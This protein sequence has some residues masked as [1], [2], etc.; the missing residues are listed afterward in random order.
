MLVVPLAYKPPGVADSTTPPSALAEK[1]LDW[2]VGSDFVFWM[3]LRVARDQ[4]IERV[5]GTPPEQVSSASAADQVRV[6]AI[7]NDILPVSVRADGLRNE[8]RVAK[9]RALRP[10]SDPRTDIDLQRAR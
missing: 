9:K 6:T 3:A 7:L 2:L 4:V 5:P 10:G 8:S 1:A